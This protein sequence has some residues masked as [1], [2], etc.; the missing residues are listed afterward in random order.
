VLRLR[1]LYVSALNF[2]VASAEARIT[3]LKPT[4][5]ELECISQIVTI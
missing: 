3:T 5:G 1:A 2:A 4:Q